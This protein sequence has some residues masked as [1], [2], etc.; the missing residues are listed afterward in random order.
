MQYRV[1]ILL[2]YRCLN[3]S[4]RKS[5]PRKSQQW[6]DQILPPLHELHVTILEK[7]QARTFNETREYMICEIDQ[8]A[9][10]LGGYQ[11]SE[12]IHTRIALRF[13]KQQ[14]GLKWWLC[15]LARVD[16][17]NGSEITRGK[18]GGNVRDSKYTNMS[19]GEIITKTTLR[20]YAVG[21]V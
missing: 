19:P 7:P 21:W 4:V 18:E 6:R 16:A 14:G 3:A 5:T 13:N 12:C 9:K 8:L 20:A 15:H 2:S 1:Q 11:G 10:S 17:P